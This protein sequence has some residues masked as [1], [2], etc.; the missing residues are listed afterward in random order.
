MKISRLSS[1]FSRRRRR[2]AVVIVALA[3]LAAFAGVP[4]VARAARV[5]GTLDRFQ[6]A[7]PDP[8]RDLHFQNVVTQDTYLSPSH[9]DGSFAAQ[10][11]PGVYDIRTESGVILMNSVVVGDVD[12]A[13]GPVH[14]AGP[15]SERRIFERQAI[16]P[17]I[18]TSPAPSTAFIMTVDQTVV[19]TNAQLVPKRQ[20]NWS[21]TPNDET[22][23]MK[24]TPVTPVAPRAT[25][26]A[27]S[28]M[29][30]GL[31]PAAPRS[32]MSQPPSP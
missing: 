4:T 26:G 1:E 14:E 12:V 3:G 28:G 25:S 18:L 21:K 10:L 24:Q 7:T 22:G 9:K 13:V 2:P 16:A 6:S 27:S 15:Y 30:M 31:T 5:S 19:S 32:P 17:S 29:P 23:E 20:F 8:S 11:P